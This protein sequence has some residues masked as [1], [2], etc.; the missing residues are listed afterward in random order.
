MQ[1]RHEYKHYINYSDYI[2]LKHRLDAVMK[3]DDHASDNNQYHIRSLYF[4]NYYDKA[5]REKI[6]G[7]NIREKFR[8]RMYNFSDDFIRLEKK[9]KYNSLCNKRSTIISKEQVQDIINGKYDFL[10]YSEDGLMVELYS[11]MKGQLLKP[12]TIVD[13]IREPYVFAPGNVRVT[14]DRNIKTSNGNINM[15]DKNI[16]MID[17]S[18]NQMILEVKYDNFLPE[19]IRC[20]VN[21]DGRRATAFSKYGVSR[22]YG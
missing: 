10:S 15:L 13:Y 18:E 4:D 19:I 9:S 8:I 17:S 6:D 11:K 2:S 22:I 1:F 20:A 3:I 12:K 14:I 7:I 21:L 5:L 16:P